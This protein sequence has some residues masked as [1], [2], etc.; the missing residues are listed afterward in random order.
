MPDPDIQFT[1][2][3]TDHLGVIFPAGH[4]V[5][6]PAVPLS[7]SR[8]LH[9]DIEGGLQISEFLKGRL[10][11]WMDREGPPVNSRASPIRLTPF[12]V[13]TARL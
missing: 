2:L 1:P 4:P 13:L 3:F 9:Q 5:E 8:G 6:R 12:F 10:R 7:F 11:S